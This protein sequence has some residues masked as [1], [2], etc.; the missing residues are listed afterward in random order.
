MNA[1]MAIFFAHVK[2]LISQ[3]NNTSSNCNI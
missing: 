2:P 3:S 1:N